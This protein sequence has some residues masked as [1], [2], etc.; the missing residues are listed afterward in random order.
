MTGD[1]DF[2]ALVRQR[3]AKTGESYPAARRQLRGKQPRFAAR[4]VA[5]FRT[6]AGLAFGCVVEAGSVSRGMGV[7]VIGDGVAREATVLSLRR[8]WWDVDRV[9]AGESADSEFGMILEPPYIGP[10]PARVIG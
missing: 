4:A 7:T 8:S 3:A 5:I 9:A 2:K 6:P 10:L 1:R